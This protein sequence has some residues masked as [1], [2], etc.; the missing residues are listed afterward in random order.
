M[1]NIPAPIIKKI[2]EQFILEENND[3]N[4]K[5]KYIKKLL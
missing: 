3:A 5:T 1:P 4:I 2:K